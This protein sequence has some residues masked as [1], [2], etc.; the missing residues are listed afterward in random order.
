MKHFLNNNVYILIRLIVYFKVQVLIR[1][2]ICL[3]QIWILLGVTPVSI[4]VK[5]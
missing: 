2:P 1:H 5:T 3:Q 4:L